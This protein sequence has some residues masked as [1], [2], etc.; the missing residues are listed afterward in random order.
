MRLLIADTSAMESNIGVVCA[1]LPCL[2]AL[3]R[4]AV[5][6]KHWSAR[7][8]LSRTFHF[9]RTDRRRNP[10]HTLERFKGDFGGR[11]DESVL[12]TSFSFQYAGSTEMDNTTVHN[13]YVS[14]K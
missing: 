7:E 11:S 9:F 6:E 14:Q 3:W 4:H 2:P 5:T 10:E 13:P 1:C 8:L 12:V